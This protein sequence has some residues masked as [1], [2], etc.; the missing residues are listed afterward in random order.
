MIV[1]ESCLKKSVSASLT[2][3]SSD[4]NF[5]DDGDLGSEELTLETARDIFWAGPWGTQ[6]QNRLFAGNLN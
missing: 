3:T 2:S 4:T 1:S 5:L 6:F